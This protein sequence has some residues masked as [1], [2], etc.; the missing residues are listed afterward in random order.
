MIALEQ[1]VLVALLLLA[2]QLYVRGARRAAELGRPLRHGRRRGA[3]FAA[4]L[5]LTGLAL[6]APFHRLADESLT[7]HMLQHVILMTFVPPLVVLAAPWMTVWRG[8]PL[9]GRRRLA[10]GVLA[11]PAWLR[12]TLAGLVAPWPAFSLIAIALGVWHLPWMYDLTLRSPLA[13]YA[14]HLSFLV[15]GTLFWIPV[16][17]SPPLHRRLDDIQAAGYLIAGAATG[18]VL[19]LVLALAPSPLYPAYADLAHRVFGVS[20]LG[21][22]Q[23][24]AGIMLGI[25]SIPYTI[26]VFWLLYRW[27]DD[28]R[29]PAAHRRRAAQTS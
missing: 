10:R 28:E 24:A 4:A 6:C 3:A 12:R 11:L 26:G 18:W 25:G 17:D 7:F 20:A 8:L 9:S 14:E 21:D 29:A 19:A 1:A 23:L 16:L 22:Q 2:G 5:V 27:L 13:H 15:F